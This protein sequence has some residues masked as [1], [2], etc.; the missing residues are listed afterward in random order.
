MNGWLLLLFTA[1]LAAVIGFITNVIAVAM[2]FRPRKPIFIGSWQL[3][4][5]PGLIPKRHEDIANHLGRIMMEHLLTVEGLQGRLTEQ[6][7]QDEVNTWVKE[8]V[9]KWLSSEERSLREITEHYSSWSAPD[10]KVEQRIKGLI[11]DRI[12]TYWGEMQAQTI[13]EIIPDDWS[14]KGRDI[15]PSVAHGILQRLRVYLYSKEGKAQ[16]QSTIQTFIRRRGSIVQMLDSFVRT[17]KMVE[18]VYPEVVDAL[19]SQDIENWLQKKLHEEYDKVLKK[20]G[21][22]LVSVETVE[23][24]RVDLTD[25]AMNQI[26]IDEVFHKPV[27][28]WAEKIDFSYVDQVSDTVIH[29][30]GRF[31]EVNM[32]GILKSLR[33]DHV[34]TEQVKAFPL[35]R[36]EAIVVNISNRELRMIK[37]LGGILGG[38]IGIVQGLLILFLI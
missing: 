27:K 11:S 37:F 26:P 31:L 6:Q 16:V 10:R 9:K 7:F 1:L 35:D 15:I 32:S 8:G 25:F 19:T 29:Q 23:N 5:T 14:Q 34:V 4:F 21:S 38:V 20:K 3:P 12:D 24:Y 36:L 13:E 22:D 33:L 18:R 17:E 28:E 30:A 2:L